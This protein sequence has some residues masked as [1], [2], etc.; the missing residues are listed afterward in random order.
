M[1]QEDAD[2]GVVTV[3]NEICFD[4]PHFETEEEKINSLPIQETSISNKSTQTPQETRLKR[5]SV[6]SKEELISKRAKLSKVGAFITAV[7]AMQTVARNQSAPELITDEFENFGK[8]V[9][10]HL[11]QLPLDVALE[12]E[13]DILHHL[14]QKRLNVT[15]K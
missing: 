14:I 3:K 6:N 5:R 8:S 1:L 10:A 13:T 4:D 11:R 15:G 2:S 9:A 12:C 7:N